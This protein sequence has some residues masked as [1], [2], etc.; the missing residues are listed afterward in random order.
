MFFLY[1]AV[2]EIMWKNIV[3]RDSPRVRI[4]CWLPKATNTHTLVVNIQC[5]STA[6]LV[7]RTRLTV[8]LHV[9]CLS[10]F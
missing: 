1:R 6:K 5:F 4:E 8:T 7:A 9:H 10:C 3:E 2:Y